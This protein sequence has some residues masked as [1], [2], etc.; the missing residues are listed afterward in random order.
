MA[1]VLS[2][3]LLLALP[4]AAA[5]QDAT[6]SVYRELAEAKT[7]D[8]VWERSLQALIAQSRAGFI[9]DPDL[10]RAEELCPGAMDA[11]FGRIAPLIREGHFRQRVEYREGLTRI[12]AAEFTPRQAEEALAFYTSPMGHQM[13]LL[14]AD[15]NSY[16]H[17][18]QDVLGSGDAPA[19]PLDRRTFDADLAGTQS[20]IHRGLDP[21]LA[22]QANRILRQ[23]RW[24]ATYAG[25]VHPQIQDLRYAI[26]ARDSAADGG[27]SAR[28]ANAATAALQAHFNDCEGAQALSADRQG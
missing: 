9:A 19:P 25:I 16:T 24:Y 27:S 21:D 1:R 2:A 5:A 8:D 26:A 14:G 4:A 7:P 11:I 23:S 28:V 13:L 20:A 15:A 17:R 12:F 22:F 6:P 18:V 10:G 3:L